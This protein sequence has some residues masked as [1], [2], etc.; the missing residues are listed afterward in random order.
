MICLF[1]K[2]ETFLYNSSYSSTFYN[3]LFLSQK[4][5]IQ[6]PEQC[7]INMRLE[8]NCEVEKVRRFLKEIEIFEK[9]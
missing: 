4:Q 5:K 8:R 6:Y 7:N 2:Y 3:I 9:I 1:R